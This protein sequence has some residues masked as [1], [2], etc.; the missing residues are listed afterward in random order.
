MLSILVLLFFIYQL[1]WWGSYLLDRAAQL[2]R[3]GEV[4][5]EREYFDYGVGALR[6]QESAKA[7]QVREEK[8]G[9]MRHEDLA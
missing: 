9:L 4:L 7:M 2:C 5:V 3:R 1:I 8:G 6:R